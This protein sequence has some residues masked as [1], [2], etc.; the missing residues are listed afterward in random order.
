MRGFWSETNW[1]LDRDALM[2]P[3]GQRITLASIRDWQGRLMVG[4][5]DLTGKWAGWRVRQQWLIPPGGTM[6]R[7]CIAQH[8]L[9][10][11]IQ[12][13]DWGRLETSRRQLALF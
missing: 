10:R 7:G 9:A 8:T 13:A 2:L 12:T 11:T 3:N 5:F 6:R 4:E 1:R